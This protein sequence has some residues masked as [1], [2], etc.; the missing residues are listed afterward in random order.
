MLRSLLLSLLIAGLVGCAKKEMPSDG[1]VRDAHGHAAPHGGQLVELGRHAYNVELVRDAAAGKLTM[2]TLDGHAQNFVRSRNTV[3]ELIAT[4]GGEKRTLN[5]IPVA[6]PA[7][8]ETVGDAAQFEAQADWLKTTSSF[9]AVLT[10]FTLQGTRF[11][12]T[13]FHF[14]SPRT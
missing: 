2:Y 13:A 3:I 7:T 9:D 4:V 8:G 1:V 14:Q 10:M 11:E 12:H 5:L 6:N